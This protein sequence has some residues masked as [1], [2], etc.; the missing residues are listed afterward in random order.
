[1]PDVPVIVSEYVPAGV[2]PVL[3]G[4]RVSMAVFVAPP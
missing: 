3:T 1:M 2:P 4:F